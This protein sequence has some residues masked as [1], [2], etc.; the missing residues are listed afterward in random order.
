MMRVGDKDGDGHIDFDDFKVPRPRPRQRRDAVVI[1]PRLTW[2]AYIRDAA[3][4][5]SE[6]LRDSVL[7][8][9]PPPTAGPV[10][11]QMPDAVVMPET[12]L[13]TY[14]VYGICCRCL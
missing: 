9:F 4:E 1:P 2:L 12:T 3:I 5:S 8:C 10:H 11:P 13:D 6:S 7:P 14:G